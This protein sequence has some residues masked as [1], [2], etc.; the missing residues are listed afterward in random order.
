MPSDA[1][2]N[3]ESSGIK[4]SFWPKIGVTI[5]I[6]IVVPDGNDISVKDLRFKFQICL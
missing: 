6:Y 3:N 1:G 5:Y 2:D 4:K